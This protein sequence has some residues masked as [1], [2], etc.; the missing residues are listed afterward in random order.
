MQ[1]LCC[2]VCVAADLG[3]CVQVSIAMLLWNRQPCTLTKLQHWTSMRSMRCCSWW[4][5]TTRAITP[6]TSFGRTGNMPGICSHWPLRSSKVVL[7]AK[8]PLCQKA[9][10]RNPLTGMNVLSM[11][12]TCCDQLSTACWIGLLVSRIVVLDTNNQRMQA[13]PQLLTY[14]QT[15]K[16]QSCCL[17]TQPWQPPTHFQRFMIQQ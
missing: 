17:G 8:L 10:R 5:K 12:S 14:L 2:K 13:Q 1:Q 16:P 6:F 7:C 4:T 3:A 9:P 15:P 11:F